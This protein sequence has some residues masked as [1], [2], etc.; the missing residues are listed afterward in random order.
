M[1]SEST[2]TGLFGALRLLREFRRQVKPRRRPVISAELARQRYEPMVESLAEALASEFGITWLPP[3]AASL[4]RGTFET[5]RWV[6][7]RSLTESP[8]WPARLDAT[9]RGVVDVV[10]FEGHPAL[11]VE[12]LS[13]LERSR[14]PA[15]EDNPW[16]VT[17]QVEASLYGFWTAAPYR[18]RL[19]ADVQLVFEN[20]QM[21]LSAIASVR[22]R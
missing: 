19:G 9:V 15:F 4:R 8:D 21:V 1:E 20:D 14:M 2:A 6:T 22:R 3:E 16:G 13:E 11:P 5:R 18:D 7:D 10:D 12:V 17:G